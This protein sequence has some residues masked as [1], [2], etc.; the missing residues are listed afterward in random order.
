MKYDKLNDVIIS[1]YFFLSKKPINVSLSLYVS[2]IAI[3]PK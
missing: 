3:Y 2:P 1:Y